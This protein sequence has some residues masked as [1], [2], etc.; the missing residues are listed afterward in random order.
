MLAKEIDKTTKPF[1]T[2]DVV[3]SKVEMEFKIASIIKR[4][5]KLV[6][7]IKK[8]FCKGIEGAIEEEEEEEDES[9][10]DEQGQGP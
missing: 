4:N 2:Y 10:E 5:D 6:K 7:K 1:G 8:K 9:E 3:K